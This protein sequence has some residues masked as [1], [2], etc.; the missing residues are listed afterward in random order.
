[1]EMNNIK[2][3]IRRLLFAASSLFLLINLINLW[4]GY[5]VL[6][7]NAQLPNG[8]CDVNTQASLTINKNFPSNP[9]ESFPITITNNGNIIAAG[10]TV[11]MNVPR[12]NICLN[13]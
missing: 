12:T 9:A 5:S 4:P 2:K 1:M 11:S 7:A 6:Y 8:G 13:Q 3:L 10:S